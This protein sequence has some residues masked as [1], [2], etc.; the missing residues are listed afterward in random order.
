MMKHKNAL[1][2]AS[3]L[4]V[5]AMLVTLLPAQSFA[6]APETAPGDTGNVSS[7][8]YL[9]RLK[10][11][12]GLSAL[13]DPTAGLEVVSRS[14]NLYLAE[15]MEQIQQSIPEAQIDYIEPNYKLQLLDAAAN[16][17]L[18]A[19]GSQWNLDALHVPAAWAKGQYGSGVTVAV[20]DSGLYGIGSSEQHE[21]IDPARIVSPHN[22]LDGGA[23]VPDAKG[24]GTFVA[25]EI[26]ATS[27]NGAGV[28]GILPEVKIMPLKVFG[29]GDADTSNVIAAMEYAVENGADVIN[30]SLGGTEYSKALEDACLSA[31]AA[32]VLVIAAAGNDGTSALRYPA[33]FDSVIGVA[34]LTSSNVPYENSQ[35]GKSVY[36]AAP[37][38]GLVGVGAGT[39][40]YCYKT[41]TSVAAPEVAALA[42]MAKSVDKSMDQDDFKHLIR[43]TST[44]LGEEGFDIYYGYGLINFEAAAD[45]LL[46]TETQTH[47]YG[48]W[49]SNGSATHSRTCQ[50]DG[51]TAR[52]TALHVWDAG[53]S[54]TDGIT[55]TCT[56]C[57]Y[58][59]VSENPLS[60]E[61]EYQ[62]IDDGSAVKLTRYCGTQTQVIVPSEL[63]VDGAKLPVT[64]LGNRIFLESDIFQLELPDSITAVEDGYASTS[65]IVGACAFCKN[66]TIV[67]LSPNLA[68]I[69]DY[70]FY[71]AGSSYR[72]ELT[73]PR[74]VQ[75]VGISAFSLCNSLTELTLPESVQQIDNSAFY[76][77]RRLAKLN[78]PGVRIVEADAFTETI[79]E[80]QYE[81]QWK[82]GTFTGV[83]YAGN[84]AYLY[85]GP[86]TGDGTTD[87]IP[88]RMPPDSELVLRD[89]T[90]GVSEFLFSSHYID[91]AS[92]RANLKSITVP[93]TLTFLPDDL[94][95]SCENVTLRGFAGSY[96]Q[97]YAGKYDNVQFEAVAAGPE[98]DYSYDW[99]DSAP[100]STY[101]L[102]TAAD[103]RGLADILDIE[104]D[105]FAG[106]TILLD[107]DV[108]LEGLID[109]GY[110]V[111]ANQWY[112][113]SGFQGTLDG[114]GHTISGVYM[115]APTLDEQGFFTQL[116]AS[117]AVKN[118]TVNGKV[119][120]R[121]SV[122]G[123]VGKNVGGSIENCAYHGSISGGG[124][125]GYIGGIAGYASGSI[126]N[127][128]VSGTVTC[129][130]QS[131]N[132]A[133]LTG[134][135]GGI[136]GYTGVSTIRGCKN[137][138]AVT[139]NAF[140]IGGIAGQAIMK[141]AISDCV[142][143]GE[144]RGAQFVGGI[145]GRVTASGL[146][147]IDGCTNNGRVS[148]T[149]YA[150]GI[151]GT[152]AGHMTS[153][154]RC[155]NNGEI[156]AANY[157]AGVLA[158]SEAG[159]IVQCANTGSV[160]AK[161]HAAGIIAK[162]S[163]FGVWES[164]NTGSITATSSLAAGITAFANNANDESNM[165]N[166]YNTGL[167][168]APSQAAPLAN[169]YNNGDIFENCYYLADTEDASRENHVAKTACAFTYGEVAYLLGDCFGQLIGIDPA[170]VFR[171]DENTVL[172]KDNIY[173]NA[174]HRHSFGA[175][176]VTTPATC[177]EPGVESRTCACGVSETRE[178]SAR[179][180]DWD[181]GKVTTEPTHDAEGV[182]TFTCKHCGETKNESIPKLPKPERPFT[183]VKEGAWYYDGIYACYDLGL[184]KGDSGTTFSP[185]GEMTRAMFATVL[186]RM[187][188]SPETAYRD[189]FSDV[190]DG[191]WYSG[192]VVWAASTGIVNG[193][194]DGSFQPGKRV[195]REEMV[196]MLCRYAK[197]S[198]LDIGDASSE[199][200]EFQDGGM[201]Q[202]YAI[203]ALS[204]AVR[205]RLMEGMG[206]GMLAPRSTATRAQ[207]AAL[208]MRFCAR[209]AK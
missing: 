121:D 13:E 59:M 58:K 82:A 78:M 34:A 80:E 154:E 138:A 168:N 10:A 9:V 126:L 134:A 142:N 85:F 45:K 178:L 109:C 53:V 166:C 62:L 141:A 30:L 50:D 135:V 187:A 68:K 118:L 5:L 115:N 171:T 139:G 12:Q 89:G 44:D 174:S 147:I 159:K 7:S 97:S 86:H 120:G 19:N 96:A 205:T 65:G 132:E 104:E 203:P 170:P 69:A 64:A 18:Y 209:I 125:Y 105:S 37:G 90:L 21:D 182:R 93:E 23:D 4:L 146:R 72:L 207:A 40:Q 107:A 55:Y 95:R 98:Q 153:A 157:A 156:E 183:D 117:A 119:C 167:V 184:L 185:N 38:A 175:W 56:V 193:Y 144:I 158:Y 66:L 32:G 160:T 188:H 124:Q 122:G 33:A 145:V 36:V 57:G 151:A 137:N 131:I 3:L 8:G 163:G 161:S 112:G 172:K 108:D 173:Y 35:Y 25:G 192:A 39:N 197:H 180:H 54:G 29:T 42:A 41:G 186:Y 83:V 116:S 94:F 26:F 194:P 177:T 71:G 148:G 73:I 100:G 60:S 204:W 49:S 67:K 92:C 84:V 123:I 201:V 88:S 127:C 196:T 179:G 91:A 152:F 14:D 195:T 61:W 11:A 63:E 103:L 102:R 206:N 24:H 155:I 16:D 176:T 70:M 79:F 76:Q 129:T 51:C 106:K 20:I 99:Y 2:I 110:G 81:N 164:Y 150:G 27:N 191:I 6:A 136:V 169:V 48:P 162:D 43:Q 143:C 189:L 199:L 198:G 181:E 165:V 17:T 52:E 1:R 31:V 22:F 87:D 149:T 47:P 113:L 74:G 101:V 200:S 75:E 77:A 46:G 140:S 15:S 111:K 28:A 128:S 202:R 114:Q 190:A 133:L 208:L 130:L